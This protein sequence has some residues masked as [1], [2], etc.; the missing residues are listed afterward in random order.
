M[1]G[2][3]YRIVRQRRHTQGGFTLIETM[4]AIV[5]LV[6]GILGLAAIL[7]DGLMYM[8]GSQVDYIAQQKASEAVESIFTARNMGQAT[9]DSI[10]N[11]GDSICA[12]GIFSAGPQSLCDPGADGIIGTAD[13]N[14]ATLADAILL[15]GTSSGT[16]SSSPV[17]L[18][19]SAYNF[20]RTITITNVPGIANLRQIQVTITYQA[21]KVP[22]TY[23][24]ISNI[25]NFS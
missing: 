19:L 17:R 14:C 6:I 23:T 22:R 18:P 9:W 15:P 13:D 10:C 16:Y 7:A 1:I 5:V 4:I 12:G 2:K 24:M 25:S 3:L 21:G 8:K 11:V 20:Q